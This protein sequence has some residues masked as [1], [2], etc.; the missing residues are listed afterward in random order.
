MKIASGSCEQPRSQK[1]LFL[2][3]ESI[4]VITLVGEMEMSILY[5]MEMSIVVPIMSKAPTV[6]KT[7]M[8]APLA[9]AKQLVVKLEVVILS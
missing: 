6:R 9:R 8:F 7:I 2:K 1:V 3:F 5:E 4:M